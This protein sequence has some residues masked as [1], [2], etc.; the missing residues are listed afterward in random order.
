MF[1]PTSRSSRPRLLVGAASALALVGSIG[2]VAG[3]AGAAIKVDATHDTVVCS[4]FSGSVKFSQ[5]ETTTGTTSPSPATDT[6]KGSLSG[7]TVGD[8]GGTPVAVTAAKLSGA[9][10]NPSSLHKCGSTG[11][12]VAV[13]GSLSITWKATPKLTASSTVITGSS[14]TTSVDLTD[15]AVDFTIDG[16]GATGPFGGSNSGAGDVVA[17]STGANS[18]T[19]LLASCGSKKGLKGL[20]LSSPPS[21]SAAS[22]G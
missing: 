22:L 14:A 1:R 4:G 17:G 16:S 9:L 11:A 15:S 13:T 19:G 6:L 18:V 12:P 5:P 2:G 20:T 10:T 8:G 3:V 21:G 7:C